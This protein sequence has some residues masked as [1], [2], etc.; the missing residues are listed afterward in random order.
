[1][2]L[3]GASVIRSDYICTTRIGAMKILYFTYASP[4]AITIAITPR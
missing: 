1:M 4:P 3:L 2:H